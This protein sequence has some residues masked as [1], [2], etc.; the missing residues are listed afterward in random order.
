M[1]P[2]VFT[3]CILLVNLFLLSSFLM[4]LAA[5]DSPVKKPVLFYN[6]H[7]NA[8]GEARYLPD[9][10]YKEILTRLAAE[11]DVRVHSQPLNPQSLAGVKVLLIANPS[12]KAVGTNPPPAHVTAAD[13]ET[14]D[15]FVRKGGGLIVMENQENHNLEGG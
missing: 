13:I 7:Y 10:T 2:R 1:K 15:E 3:T 14:L 5:A 8:L 9:G 11:F 6:R 4:D 12:D